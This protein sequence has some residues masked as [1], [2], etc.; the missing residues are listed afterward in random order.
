MGRGEKDIAQLRDLGG[1]GGEGDERRVVWL[2]PVEEKGGKGHGLAPSGREEKRGMAQTHGGGAGGNGH[3][4]VLSGGRGCGWNIRLEVWELSRWRVA[5]L[6][7]MALLPPN[8]QPIRSPMGW[9]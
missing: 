9:M 7:T 3:G 4:L 2:G 1:G 6:M 5:I 8:S